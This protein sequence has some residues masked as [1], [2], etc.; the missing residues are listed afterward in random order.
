[1]LGVPSGAQ[2]CAVVPCWGCSNARSAS[3]KSLGRPFR[4][5]GPDGEA[6]FEVVVEEL[7]QGP[8]PPRL[9]GFGTPSSTEPLEDLENRRSK[10]RY[11]TLLL[12]NCQTPSNFRACWFLAESESLVE[13]TT[14][15]WS[16]ALP[17]SDLK[18][19]MTSSWDAM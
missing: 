1:M 11:F 4:G 5:T 8:E 10:F 16:W 12:S 15:G 17:P 7:R 14:M 19:W 18:P 6:Y 13:A 3:W 9:S 2:R